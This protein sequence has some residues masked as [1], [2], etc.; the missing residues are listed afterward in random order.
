MDTTEALARLSESTD[1]LIKWVETLEMC[2]EHV[3]TWV[4][5][6]LKNQEKAVGVLTTALTATLG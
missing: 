2:G 1:Q 6:N 3:P 4:K 5:V